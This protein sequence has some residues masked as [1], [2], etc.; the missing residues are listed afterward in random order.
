MDKL[1]IRDEVPADI[2]AVRAVETAAFGRPEEAQLV[3]LLRTNGAAVISLVAEWEGGIAG[4]ILFSPV[5]A[6]DAPEARLLG[7]APVAVAPGQQRGGIGGALIRAGLA[8]AESLGCDGVVLLGHPEY[9]PRFGFVPAS[10]FGI[11]CEY[12]CPDEAFMALPLREGGLAGVTGLVRYA[13]EF[14]TV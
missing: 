12:D 5:T 9:Y 7:L 6:D 13:P 11:C 8:R 10:R 4:H 14:A 3:D 1:H 2:D